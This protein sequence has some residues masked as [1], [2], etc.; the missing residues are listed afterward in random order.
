MIRETYW[1][2]VNAMV[3]ERRRE[4]DV[5]DTLERIRLPELI[6]SLN[7]RYPFEGCYIPQERNSRVPFI[8]LIKEIYMY[9]RTKQEIA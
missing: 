7:R 8:Q 3:S 9:C 5:F 4:L 1:V 2:D 6:T